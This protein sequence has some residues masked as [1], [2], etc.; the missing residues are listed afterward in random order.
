[1]PF[2]DPG[3]H[4]GDILESIDRISEF[5]GD[6]NFAA[7]QQ[8][9]KTKAAVERKM[10][11]LTEAVIRLE[12]EGPEAYPDIDW[13]AYRGMGNFLRHSYHRVSDE[14]VWNTVND[15]LPHLRRI[16]EKALW[17]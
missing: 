3:R 6:M 12:M 1:M 5:I 14:I 2:K 17:P 15:D 16:V 10:Q 7:Y 11:V 9:D 13:K 4:L 8:D